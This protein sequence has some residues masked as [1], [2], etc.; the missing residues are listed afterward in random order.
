MTNEFKPLELIVFTDAHYY[1]KKLG[2]DTE[3][4]KKRDAGDQKMLKDSAEILAAAFA[5]IAASDCPNVIFCGDATCD[6]D[7][8]SHAEFIAMLY[9]LKK[10]GKRVL[11]ITSTHDFQDSGI[12][13]K[14]TGAVREEIKSVTRDEIPAMY[15]QFGP[16]EATSLYKDGLSF[17]TEL[18]ENYGIFALNSDKDGMGRSGYSEDMR[19]WLKETAEKATTEGKI[20]LAFTHHPLVSP[21]PFYSLIGKNDMMGGHKEIRE[22][23]ADLGINLVF[24]G[25]SHIHD[26]SYI[27]SEKGNVMYDI[28]T[29]A[30]AGYPGYMRKVTVD[31]KTATVTSEQ[32]TKPVKIKFNGHNLQEHLYNKFFG[33]VK[34][35]LKAAAEDIHTFADCAVGISI[36]KTTS[37]KWGWAIKPIA[38]ILN[39]LTIGNVGAWTKKETGLNEFDYIDIRN[40][41]VIDFILD[42]VLH[43]YEGD[44]PYSP[45]TP[46]YKITVGLL[47]IIES[48]LNTIRL[49]FSK[50]LKGY[51]R[52][53]D[54]ILPLLYNSGICDA[55]AQLTLNPTKDDIEAL[56]NNDFIEKVKPSKKGPFIIA[57]LVLATLA[58]IPFLPL[59]A[60]I[61]SAYYLTYRIKYSKEIRGIER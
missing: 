43:L 27:V 18:D 8:D 12:T 54:L 16:D 61:V 41:K 25:H 45:D 47:N 14:Y 52:P 39:R 2:V 50:I 7:P 9:A 56:C 46:Q 22:M 31:G 17:Y 29:S 42:L 33:T 58:L 37:Y 48:I 26:I 49:P 4:Y 6:G 11:A 35:I 10:C 55:E 34:L 57:T 5:Q 20:L 15:R 59:I 60:V 36:K 23:L 21:S 53:H 19:E 38:K 32:I 1:S 3:S 30:L 28:S 40:D 51:E 44:A 24:T 13:H